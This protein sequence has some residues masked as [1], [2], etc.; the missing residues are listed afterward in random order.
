MPRKDLEL[1]QICEELFV[2]VIDSLAYSSPWSQ[3]KLV[4]KK[5]ANA[6]YTWH[7]RLPCD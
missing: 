6:K 2:F 5:P 4:L 3:P 7:S 1:F